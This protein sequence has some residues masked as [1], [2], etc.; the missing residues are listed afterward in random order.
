MLTEYDSYILADGGM[1]AISS[2]GQEDAA[3]MYR[4]LAPAA[5]HFD[6]AMSSAC[7]P[8]QPAQPQE[9]AYTLTVLS[10]ANG[11]QPPGYSL[12]PWGSEPWQQHG[13]AHAGNPFDDD[14]VTGS[15]GSSSPER[16]CVR[17]LLHVALQRGGS[18]AQQYTSCGVPALPPMD[19]P[20]PASPAPPCYLSAVKQEP[21][22]LASPL[23]PS[24]A[25]PCYLSSMKQEQSHL[26]DQQLASPGVFVSS[27]SCCSPRPATPAESLR[28]CYSPASSNSAFMPLAPALGDD[29]GV[30]TTT[31]YL[32]HDASASAFSPAPPAYSAFRTPYPTPSPDPCLPAYPRPEPY[33]ASLVPLPVHLLSSMP[34]ATPPPTP[35]S[36]AAKRRRSRAAAALNGGV[37]PA[38][39]KR[40]RS[41]RQLHPCT[42][43]DKRFKDNYSVNV[44][45]RTHTG[46]KPFPCIVCG[47]MFRQKAHLAKHRSTHQPDEYAAAAAAMAQHGAPL[48]PM[49]SLGDVDGNSNSL[50]WSDKCKAPNVWNP[51]RGPMAQAP[52]LS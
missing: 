2:S 34:T 19:A 26:T 35:T 22:P 4:D 51:N 50:L 3:Y 38:P 20:L 48:A 37:A 7:W 44:H 9:D 33:P 10:D 12:P 30:S 42:L 41:E 11:G 17:S 32:H 36:R 31:S 21:M 25:P 16:R 28:S 27:T 13:P 46:E 52:A 29:A 45:M 47:K 8:Q 15:D 24:P 40:E 18:F 6:H 43:C 39:R 14:A 23:T 5:G 1:D 49:D